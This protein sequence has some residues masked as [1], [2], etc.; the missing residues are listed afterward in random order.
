MLITLGPIVRS[1]AAT[2]VGNESSEV[3]TPTAAVVLASPALRETIQAIRRLVCE[4]FCL[5]E[6]RD[7]ELT[8]RSNRRAYVLPRQLAMY[9]TRQLTGASGGTQAGVEGKP[10]NPAWTQ[11]LNQLLCGR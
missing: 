2:C 4:H 10:I 9:I 11:A 3:R 1:A 8:V 7:P 5:R 6:M